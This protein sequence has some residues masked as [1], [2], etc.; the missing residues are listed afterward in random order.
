MLER[1]TPTFDWACIPPGTDLE[2]PRLSVEDA[3]N[4]A[5]RVANVGTAQRVGTDHAWERN[6]V[7]WETLLGEEHGQY[8]T[9]LG[10]HLR[11]KNRA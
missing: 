9:Y 3:E 4:M 5:R 2:D 7:K 6:G 1:Y 8:F 10:R 11:C